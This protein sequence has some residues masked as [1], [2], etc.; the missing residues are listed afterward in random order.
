VQLLE[1]M[2]PT[3]CGEGDIESHASFI[4]TGN[5]VTL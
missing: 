4:E 1:A 3:L 5:L 2:S